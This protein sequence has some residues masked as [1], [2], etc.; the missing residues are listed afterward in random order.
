VAVN[1]HFFIYISYIISCLLVSERNLLLFGRVVLATKV[2]NTHLVA[3]AMVVLGTADIVTF[4][5]LNKMVGAPGDHLPPFP[6]LRLYFI[7][8]CQ[9][10][11]PTY[12][13]AACSNS[14]T[15]FQE[16]RGTAFNKTA[17]RH[18]VFLI[19]ICI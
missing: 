8:R 9:Q 11:L 6:M 1:A 2:A 16:L 12:R 10:H 19:N 18:A 17:P 3:A 14:S 15:H 4:L 5:P 13:N 7:I